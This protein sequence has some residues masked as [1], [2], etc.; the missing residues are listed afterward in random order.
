MEQ[1]VKHDYDKILTRLTVILQR[2]YEGEILTVSELAEEFNVDARTLRRDFKERLIR[3]PIEKE[4]RGWKMRDG[5]RLERDRKPDEELVLDMLE[6][7]AGGV[8][9]GFRFAGLHTAGT[10]EKSPGEC[11]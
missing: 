11:N 6:T 7:L 2:L 9:S 4:G 5:F 10:S 3:F 8:G 1:S